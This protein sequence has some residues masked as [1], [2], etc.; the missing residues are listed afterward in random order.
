MKVVRDHTVVIWLDDSE[1]FRVRSRDESRVIIVD[2][3]VAHVRDEER[4]TEVEVSG[5][6]IKADGTKSQ[7]RARRHFLVNEL[8]VHVR[9]ELVGAFHR[10]SSVSTRHPLI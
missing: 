9:A 1:T 2:L 8:P 4:I 3:V 7:P 10:R 5:R 6:W